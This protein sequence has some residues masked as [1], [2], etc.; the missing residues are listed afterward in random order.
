M[1]QERVIYPNTERLLLLQ[2][3]GP[4]ACRVPER[5]RGR[6][7]LGGGAGVCTGPVA[8]HPRWK[9]RMVLYASCL[10][11]SG[12]GRPSPR[13]ESSMEPEARLQDLG[14][15]PPRGSTLPRSPSLSGQELPERSSRVRFLLFHSGVDISPCL[16]WA[17]VG[18]APTLW[19][20]VPCRPC[21]LGTQS[22]PL[23]LPPRPAR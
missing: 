23:S 13:P 7:A 12:G 5:L 6:C 1:S 10:C 11:R 16:C 8:L 4:G 17:L 18:P 21:S 19:P 22:C 3:G 15:Q 2:K 9:S 20:R 14:L